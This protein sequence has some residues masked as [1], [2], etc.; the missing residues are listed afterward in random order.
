MQGQGFFGPRRFYL[1]Q[2]EQPFVLVRLGKQV[3]R[4]LQ[5]STFSPGVVPRSLAHPAAGYLIACFAQICALTIVVWLVQ[6]WPA[7]HFRE[8]LPLLAILLVALGWGTGPSIVAT[9][10]GTLL[11]ILLQLPSLRTTTFEDSIGIGIYFGVGLMISVLTSQV[12]RARYRAERL[13]GNLSAMLDAIPDAVTIYDPQ[14]NVVRMNRQ[15]RE[16]VP[17]TQRLSLSEIDRDL[18]IRTLKGEPLP[19]QELPLTR[20]LQGATINSSEMIIQQ[21]ETQQDRYVA[22]SAAPWRNVHGEIEGAV[23]VTRDLSDLHKAEWEAAERASLLETTFSTM[24]DAVTV[25]NLEGEIIHINPV[26]QALYH[27]FAGGDISHFSLTKR[28]EHII[29]HDEHGEPLTLDQIPSVRI[30]RGEHL[31]GK[32]AVTIRVTTPTGRE[33]WLHVSGAPITSVQGQRLGAVIIL[34]DETERYALEQRTRK[35]L[36]ALLVMAQTVVFHPFK[37][38]DPSREQGLE[39]LQHTVQH[40]ADLAQ[41]VLNSKR[42]SISLIDEQTG[43]NTPLAVTGL[44]IEQLEQWW[45]EV[46]TSSANDYLTPELLQQLQA[47]ETPILD[48][49]SQPPLSRN[50]YGF[51]L[52]LAIPLLSNNRLIGLLAVDNGQPDQSY[53]GEDIAV[54]RAVAQLT[55]L[56]IEREQ[57][58]VERT[59][60]RASVLALQETNR[61]MNEFLSIAAHEIRTPL[62]TIRACLQLSQRQLQRLLKDEATLSSAAKNRLTTTYELT[63][64]AVHQASR[65][66]RLVRDLLDVS[67]IQAGHLNLHPE[68][69]DL[70]ALVNSTVL[71]QRTQTPNRTISLE[72]PEDSLFVQ[73]DQDRIEQVIDNYLS[74]ALKYSEA[75]KAVLVRVEQVEPEQARVLVCDQGPGLPLAQQQTIWERFYRVPGVEVKSGSGIGLGLGLHISRTIIEQ[76]GGM[77]GI[78]SE[79][80]QGSTFW[81]TLPLITHETD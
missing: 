81:F 56:V 69:I 15:A 9:L 2:Q 27:E 75:D 71:D 40:L 20:A 37:K 11:L 35:A 51:G 29:I 68:I 32:Q 45:S 19:L 63:E 50:Y 1:K 60:A 25:Y 65:Q 5:I 52:T 18:H 36:E 79:P 46:A 72:I 26:A 57:L 31:V 17:T 48:L 42:M 28:V 70:V 66:T 12:Q 3:G 73:A 55:T 49:A 22:V 61:L 74:N 30:L 64:R 33:I 34:R 23:T 54:A 47:G 53:T 67:R 4:W 41:P 80:E 77:V 6:L 44:S 59:E 10:T 8:A 43:H 16:K 21:P 58:E 14:G 7:I 62:T 76:L 39:V 38:E 24:T 78:E 13:S